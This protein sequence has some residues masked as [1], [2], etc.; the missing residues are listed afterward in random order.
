MQHLISIQGSSTLWPPMLARSFWVGIITSACAA[1]LA[2]FS[3]ALLALASASRLARAS[4]SLLARSS[5]A[6]RTALASISARFWASARQD[7]QVVFNLTLSEGQKD[8]S[9]HTVMKSSLTSS[10]Y[11]MCCYK[12]LRS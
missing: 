12:R 7:H 3:V 2:L 8:H 10:D 9:N 1:S 11:R 4:A 6:A 5:S